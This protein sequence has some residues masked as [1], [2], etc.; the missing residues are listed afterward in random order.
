MVV[1]LSVLLCSSLRNHGL[2]FANTIAK[3]ALHIH[4]IFASVFLPRTQFVK[5]V[6]IESDQIKHFVER[7]IV[8]LNKF[9]FYCMFSTR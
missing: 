4:K 3:L 5:G 8:H 2:V 6:N 9:S 7:A 1:Y